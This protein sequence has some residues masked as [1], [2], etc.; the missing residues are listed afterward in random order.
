MLKDIKIKLL[1][2]QRNYLQGKVIL[3]KTE[4]LI[5]RSKKLQIVGLML[6]TLSSLS[7]V[8]WNS[9]SAVETGK[10]ATD[11]ANL[12]FV[13][14][15]T[16]NM[17]WDVAVKIPL[18]VMVYKND[19]KEKLKEGGVKEVN[20]IET[21]DPD[22]TVVVVDEN[23]GALGTIANATAGMIDNSPVSTG[24]YLAYLSEKASVGP[25]AIYAAPSTTTAAQGYDILT[26]IIKLWEWARNIV[27]IFYVIVFIVIGI[28]IIMRQRIGGQVPIT[29][30][31]SIPNVLLSLVLVTFSYAI[32]G[33]IIDGMHLVTGVV[34][35]GFFMNTSISSVPDTAGEYSF[36]SSSM[37]VFSIFGT[38]NVKDFDTAFELGDIEGVMGQ[39]VINFVVAIMEDVANFDALISAVIS[40][41]AVASMFKIFFTLLGKYL[42]LMLSPL[43]APFQ[44]FWGSIPGH[45]D[46][47]WSWFKGMLSNVG[48]FVGIYV[49]FCIMIVLTDSTNV[50]GW[51]WYPPLTGFTAEKE[52][53]AHLLA[54]AL[55]IAAPNVPALIEK[56]IQSQPT[57]MFGGVGQ[58]TQGA[59]GKLAGIAGLQ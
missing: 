51:S 9:A 4:N 14:G 37:S 25:K 38:A 20:V 40:I 53:I 11:T 10:G 34:H 13:D 47:I 17:I 12:E 6:I 39:K 15:N 41:A 7:A 8:F 36:Q 57:G 2:F 26:P 31:N 48:A 49:V 45:G 44:F 1:K 59:L 21:D 22:V 27:Y 50:T 55:F 28:M 3:A 16:N 24:Q 43:T 32:S 33:L 23:G 18:G 54:Y 30:I 58:A 46:A 5:S 56:A 52:T 42:G 29:I 35:Y 19:V